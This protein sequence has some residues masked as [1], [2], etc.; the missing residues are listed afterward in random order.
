MIPLLWDPFFSSMAVTIMGGLMFASLLTLV[1]APVFYFT[2]FPGAR[3][4][5]RLA[6]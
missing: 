2:L 3:R 4:D 1:A 5:E 6:A